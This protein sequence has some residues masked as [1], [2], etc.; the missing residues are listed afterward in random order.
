M[1]MVSRQNVREFRNE[2]GCRS[3][4]RDVIIRE[5]GGKL[6]G[7]KLTRKGKL[8]ESKAEEKSKS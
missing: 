8:V 2:L 4:R 5:M 6:L 1:N 3:K 7:K